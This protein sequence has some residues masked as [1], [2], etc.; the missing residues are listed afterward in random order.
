MYNSDLSKAS[1]VDA[2]G[3][4][5]IPRL[6]LKYTSATL[7][8]LLL[9]A[10]YNLTDT[11]FVSWGVGDNAMGGVSVVLPF[12]LLQGAISTAV[13]GG[14]ASIVSRK[15]GAGKTD[16]A[17]KTTFNAMVVFYL[18]AL[19]ITATGFALINPL[20]NLFGVTAELYSAAK[21]YFIIIL[22]GNVFSTGFSSIIRAEGKMLYGTLIWIIPITINIIL[23][24]I[25]IFAL[26]WGVRGSAAATVICQFTSF[27]M[28]ILFFTKYT[29]QNIRVVK[30]DKKLI[31]EILQIGLPS[32]IQAGSLSIISAILNRALRSEIG[33]LGVNSFAYIGKIL[34]F[35]LVPLNAVALA[36]SPVAGYNY[37]AGNMTRVKKSLAI[38][39]L[40]C[41]AYAVIA[42][43]LL[44]AIPSPLMRIFTDNSEIIT[45]G[46]YGLKIIGISFLFA[47]FPIITAVMYQAVG[48]KGKAIFLYA[49]NLLFLLPLS[50]VMRNHFGMD[51]VWWS[52]VIS[53]FCSAVL[54]ILL[55]LLDYKRQVQ[56]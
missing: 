12:V 13:G 21:D 37:G 27:L 51:G 41:L 52:Y 50:A 35:A 7:I 15:L 5:S 48:K 36:L 54:S 46:A 10:V 28:C 30:P 45:L 31:I 33:T 24:A 16:E 29:S 3:R 6:M 42:L 17:G 18:T 39:I 49:A 20:L 9:N 25:F 53:M 23:D 47:P 55:I 44:V 40:I 4:E 19:I 2:L 11:L 56:S 14:A 8:A 34:F 22:A 26:G 1:S 38:S 43:I 32:L